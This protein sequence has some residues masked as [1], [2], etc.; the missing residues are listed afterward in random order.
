MTAVT[1]LHKLE[2]RY[3]GESVS[4][5]ELV[6]ARAREDGS[7]GELT[8]IFL[9]PRTVLQKGVYVVTKGK[10]YTNNIGVIE[11]V[12]P[13]E[14]CTPSVYIRYC[15]FGKDLP[16]GIREDL[17]MT[18]TQLLLSDDIREEILSIIQRPVSVDAWYVS[19]NADELS[20]VVSL[21]PPSLHVFRSL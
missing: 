21:F 11:S 4:Y 17:G 2:E 1:N 9:D 16:E 7:L 19:S 3:R 14:N 6:H 15:Y 10:G 13:S 5:E 12:H 20:V 18:S 8:S